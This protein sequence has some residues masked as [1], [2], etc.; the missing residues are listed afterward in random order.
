MH[1]MALGQFIFSLPTL[2]YNDFKRQSSWRHPS[3]SRVGARPARQSLGPGDDTISL[4]GLL[5]PEFAGRK[6][7]LNELRAM[8]DKGN[9]W[10]LVDGTGEVFGAWVIENVNETG[11]L[12]M[13][14][15]APRRIEF[16]L[17]LARVDDAQADGGGGVDPGPADDYW[18]WWL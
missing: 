7:A 12:H 18:E 8:A 14:N 17:Q 11:T 13:D 4:S 16:D 9:A 5:V 2:A 1:M 10:S 15:G 6:G 3:N